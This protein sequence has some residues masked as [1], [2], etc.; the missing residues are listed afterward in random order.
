MT[1]YR[2]SKRIG[3]SRRGDIEKLKSA[4]RSETAA[5]DGDGHVFKTAVSELRKA[6]YDIRH[7]RKTGSYV[8]HGHKQALPPAAPPAAPAPTKAS[9]AGE[10]TARVETDAARRQIKDDVA[11]L[12]R[13][14]SD[15][16]HFERSRTAQHQ[17]P[18]LKQAI[19]D[20]EARIPKRNL[21]RP[22]KVAE[23]RSSVSGPVTA[24][25]TSSPD[26]ATS[27]PRSSAS[28]EQRARM[29]ADHKRGLERIAA[30]E[31]SAAAKA[32]KGKPYRDLWLTAGEKGIPSAVKSLSNLSDADVIA[33]AKYFAPGFKGGKTA[34]R[35]AAVKALSSE[36]KASFKENLQFVEAEP[37]KAKRSPRSSAASFPTYRHAESAVAAA[38]TEIVKRKG[39]AAKAMARGQ[40][41]AAAK[42]FDAVKKAEAS[43]ATAQAHLDRPKPKGPS[44]SIGNSTTIQQIER[45]I[46]PDGNLMRGNDVYRRLLEKASD[47]E[48]AQVREWAKTQSPHVSRNIGD[49]AASV[50]RT[51]PQALPGAPARTAKTTGKLG[52]AIAVGST[53]L[54]LYAAMRGS[55]ATAAPAAPEPMKTRTDEDPNRSLHHGRRSPVQ[56][57]PPDRALLALKTVSPALSLKVD[58]HGRQSQ[59]RAPCARLDRWRQHAGRRQGPVEGGRAAPGGRRAHHRRCPEDPRPAPPHEHRAPR[60]HGLRRDGAAAGPDRDRPHR[61]A[62]RGSLA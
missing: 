13:Y 47:A 53:A 9:G 15:L 8:N 42:H 36:M 46:G 18:A 55:P 61:H 19:A 7:D 4:L 58:R 1:G 14:R 41:E 52:L 35:D 30:K 12:K 38:D 10:A 33:T 28:S 56:E 29:M 2:G 16:D 11:K 51:R 6:G 44:G 50:S 45:T 32:T 24:S 27:K 43:R 54:G 60:P 20:L 25:P 57:R 39:M 21:P 40:T 34:T 48:I 22:R 17:V 23:A 26:A 62:D 37:V 3:T 49:T 59:A 5:F 31:R